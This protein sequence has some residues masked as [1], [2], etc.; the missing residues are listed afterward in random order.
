M[1]GMAVHKGVSGM[2]TAYLV[3]R[4]GARRERRRERFSKL[5]AIRVALAFL[6]VETK[7]STRLQC[8]R[9]RMF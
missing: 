9:I 5:G 6:C 2:K 4:W 3:I 8:E 1:L 7:S